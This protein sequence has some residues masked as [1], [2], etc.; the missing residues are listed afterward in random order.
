MGIADAFDAVGAAVP[1]TFEVES[2][3]FRMRVARPNPDID[4]DATTWG[5]DG[6]ER[7]PRS[8]KD[9]MVNNDG[10]YIFFRYE[11]IFLRLG[12]VM[13]YGAFSS[14]WKGRH[15]NKV[16]IFPPAALFGPGLHTT[17]TLSWFPFI[18]SL[19]PPLDAN[20]QVV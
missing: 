9:A 1:L 16:R 10:R 20:V 15:L 3:R 2:F 17:T 5:S 8:E 6:E 4:S 18:S 12:V 19:A 13:H 14:N 7:N 11:I